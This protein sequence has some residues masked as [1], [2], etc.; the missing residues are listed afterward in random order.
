MPKRT[1]FFNQLLLYESKFSEKDFEIREA[2]SFLWRKR[3]S[4]NEINEHS[5]STC[6]QSQKSRKVTQGK[7]PNIKNES[8]RRSPKQNSENGKEG[9]RSAATVIH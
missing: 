3:F 9:V 7:I 5:N 6:C 1:R 4:D 8:S 2:P